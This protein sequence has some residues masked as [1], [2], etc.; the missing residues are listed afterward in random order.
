VVTP[1]AKR[2]AI[3]LL[4]TAHRQSVQ[5]ACR[6]VRFARAAWYRPPP[7]PLERDAAVIEAL[8]GVV[9][10]HPRWRLWKCYQRLRLL[11]DGWNHKRVHRIYRALPLNLPRRTRRRVPARVRQPLVAPAELNRTWAL[12]FLHDR[13]YDGRAFRVLT[14][15]DEGNREALGLEAS[16]SLPSGRV[17]AVLDQRV[18]LHGRLGA[19]RLDNRPEFVAG[20]LGSWAATQSIAL[21][22]IP[23]GKPD[24][25]AFIERFNRTY[26]EEVLDA[27]LFGTLAEVAEVNGTWQASDNEERP[28]D[29]LGG[30][31][32][33]TFLP[34]PTRTL[35][36]P[37]R[38]ST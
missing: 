38:P 10:Q 18:T 19:L 2:Q 6:V 9:A 12:D 8:T 27:H 16:T 22:F 30:V 7:A 35:E 29:S 4:V 5:R 31:P 34:R 1:S 25:N 37:Y 28:R 33:L 24:Q 36:S 20:V 15:L 14:G 32:P 3:A 17:A 23:P 11:G 21:H 26:R 13:R